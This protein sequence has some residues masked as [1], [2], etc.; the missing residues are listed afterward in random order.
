MGD[1]SAH[2]SKS[3]FRCRCGC[4]ALVGP[5]PDLLDY[6]E[7]IREFSGFPVIITSGYRCPDH[8][9]AVRGKPNSAH[10]TGEAADFAVHSDHERFKFLEAIYLYGP[11]RVGIYPGWLHVDVSQG[12]PE[13]VCWT[14]GID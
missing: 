2:F 14:G 3:E 4:G 10:T 1:L 7:S 13:E 6:L 5:S 9:A 8:N 11:H 12:L